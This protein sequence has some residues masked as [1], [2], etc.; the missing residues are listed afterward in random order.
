MQK[1]KMFVL[2]RVIPA[3]CLAITLAFAFGTHGV[4]LTDAAENSPGIVIEGFGK[5]NADEKFTFSTENFSV[6]A[7]ESFYLRFFVKNANEYA[8]KTKLSFTDS[9][10]NGH[11]VSNEKGM[12]LKADSLYGKNAGKSV[13]VGKNGVIEAP[14][15]FYGDLE[16]PVSAF[17]R[18]GISK[19][20]DVKSVSL[21][22]IASGANATWL[23]DKTSLY[24][25]GI[26]KKNQSGEKEIVCDFTKYSED[27]VIHEC[28]D[29]TPV[30]KA[31]RADSS[32]VALWQSYTAEKSAKRF[33]DVKIVKDFSAES[34]VDGETAKKEREND[35]Y[36]SGQKSRY[37]FV[38]NGEN[39]DALSYKLDSSDYDAG[40]NS[41][42]GIHFNFATDDERDWSG[43][44]GVTVYVKNGENFVVSFGVELFQYNSDTNLVE[45]Y[46]LNSAVNKYKTIYAYDVVTGLEFSIHTQTY[47]RIPANFEGWLRIPLSQYDAPAWSMTE[48]YG[49]KGVLDLDKFEIVKVSLTRFFTANQDSELIIDELGVYYDDFTPGGSFLGDKPSIKDNMSGGRR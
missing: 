15:R 30:L 8:V 32:D 5:M 21:T 33:G 6:G 46:N 4:R 49:N 10:N 40:K 16:F 12:M 26:Y 38:A 9:E 20:L 44:K 35:L 36:L 41:Y 34:S 24:L 11:Y 43:A 23:T 37:S 47:I 31:R 13:F 42:A 18:G 19:K 25:F 2:K 48:A 27:S 17:D 3:I 1:T 14:Y 45:Q 28:A 29:A 39:G 7:D 22:L